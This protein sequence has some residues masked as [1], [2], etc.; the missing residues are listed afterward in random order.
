MEGCEKHCTFCVVPAHA[1]PRAQ[2]P[3]ASRSWPRSAGL[4]AEGC[5]EVTLL[6]QT[7]NAYG[8]DLTPATDLAELFERV[9]DV[10]GLQRIRFTTSN[11][12]NL[13][14]QADPGDARRARRCASTFTCR[15]SPAPTACSSG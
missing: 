10:A 9:N 2:P 12:Y 13:T 11:P 7:V 4:V 14:P 6:G 3:A 1:R 8:R 15:C 5:R